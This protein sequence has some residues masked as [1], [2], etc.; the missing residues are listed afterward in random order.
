MFTVK[1]RPLIIALVDQ[2]RAL[3]HQSSCQ[4]SLHP[5]YQHNEAIHPLNIG[6]LLTSVHAGA[7]IMQ[8]LHR[9]RKTY[10]V[11]RR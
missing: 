11:L 8:V 10:R 4:F 3:L 6:T 5:L 1:T 9:A 2:I 7:G